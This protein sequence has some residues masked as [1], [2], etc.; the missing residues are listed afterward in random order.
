MVYCLWTGAALLGVLAITGSLWGILAGVGDITA[1]DG[2]KG[3]ALVALVCLAVDALTL[4]T[5]TAIVQINHI[6][7]DDES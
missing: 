2:V 5:L 7:P 1:A 3:L 4:V 6:D